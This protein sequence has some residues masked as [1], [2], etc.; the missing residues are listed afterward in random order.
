MIRILTFP[1]CVIQITP[2]W[3]KLLIIRKDI[4]GPMYGVGYESVNMICRVMSILS[5]SSVNVEL[6]YFVVCILAK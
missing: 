4:F 3:I 1:T 5:L 6:K 2:F